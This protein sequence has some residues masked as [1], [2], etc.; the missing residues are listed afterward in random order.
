MT[1]QAAYRTPPAD[2][3]GPCVSGLVNAVAKGTE[4]QLAPWGLSALEFHILGVIFR[5]GETTVS[6]IATVTPV[7]SGR[8]SRIVH[9]FY[10]RGLVSRERMTRD[11]RVVKLRLTDE[12]GNLVPHLVQLV[13]DYNKMLISNISRKD[14]TGFIA[15]CHKIVENHARHE[16]DAP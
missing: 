1:D 10:K 13:D 4:G 7:D 15:T 11:R 3:L 16:S 5:A 14:F 9:K 2:H 12:G 8:I 6:E